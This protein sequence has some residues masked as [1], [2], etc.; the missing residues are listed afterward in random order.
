[1][2]PD[3]RHILTEQPNPHSE[4]L[5]QLP[6]IDALQ[7]MEHEN[8][9]AVAAVAAARPSL[10]TAVGWAADALKGG[11]RLIYVGAGTSGRLAVLDAAE[12]PPTFSSDP[13]QILAVIAGGDAALKA[14]IE[15][16][17]DDSRAGAQAIDELAPAPRDLV[18]GIAAGGTTP[19]V[20]GALKAAAVHGAKTIL[21]CCTDPAHISLHVDLLIY[22]P[23]GPEFIT[24]S[25][26][27][28]AGTATKLALNAIS[29][30]AMVQIGKVFGN[31]MVDVDA[32]KN[33][34]LRDRAA[35][36]IESIAG[37]N[38]CHSLE[39]LDQ[40]GGRVKRAIVMHFH[41]MTADQADELLKANGGHLSR[42]IPR[43]T[44]LKRQ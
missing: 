33:V 32:G 30:L 18:I 4:N 38:R 21:I 16:A 23:T 29:T 12:C 5:D 44:P 3:R 42:L 7:M 22:L 10:A 15:G 17:E 8:A 31:F 25:T 35:R 19:F 28:K 24:G 39:L 14:S 20:H 37:L 11:G 43:P 36:M 26:R 13:G 2:I 40:A 9:A 1:M 34:K 6:I 41:H 27:L